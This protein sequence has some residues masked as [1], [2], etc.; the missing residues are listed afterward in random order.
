MNGR[1]DSSIERWLA[2]R[3]SSVLASAIAC[4][5]LASC[6]SESR[7]PV[8]LRAQANAGTSTTACTQGGGTGGG[9][10]DPLLSIE[11]AVE[12]DVYVGQLLHFRP[13][14]PTSTRW[15]PRV[16]PSP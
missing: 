3:V 16:W 4:A 15:P 14:S 13:A 8:T 9:G 12:P 10:A 11:M 6:N 2:R 5:L 1:G 7:A